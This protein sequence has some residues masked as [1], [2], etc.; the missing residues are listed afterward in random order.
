MGE[1]GEKPGL[2]GLLYATLITGPACVSSVKP[3]VK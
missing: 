1:Q 2:P 3:L